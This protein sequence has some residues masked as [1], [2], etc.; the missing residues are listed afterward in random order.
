MTQYARALVNGS[1]GLRAD[2]VVDGDP[3]GKYVPFAAEF[4]RDLRQGV[5][6]IDTPAAELADL[7]PRGR[8]AATFRPV[9]GPH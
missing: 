9:F 6:P 7:L 2:L 5:P 3:S 8:T 4:A 1:V